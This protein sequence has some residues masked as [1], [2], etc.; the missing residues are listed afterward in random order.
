MG[1]LSSIEPVRGRRF[2]DLTATGGHLV[3]LRSLFQSW[4]DYPSNS[5]ACWSLQLRPGSALAHFSLLVIKKTRD[6]QREG[7]ALQ[8][9][10]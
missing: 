10:A 9:V 4:C 8:G 2:P 3:P 5:P 1:L 7:E 6:N